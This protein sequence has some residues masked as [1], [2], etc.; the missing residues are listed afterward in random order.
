MNLSPFD[1]DRAMAYFYDGKV[2][3]MTQREVTKALDYGLALV[4]EVKLLR[5]RIEQLE[6][7]DEH[8]H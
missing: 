7:W 4:Y 6:G 3:D 5:K 8:D 2:I 1:V